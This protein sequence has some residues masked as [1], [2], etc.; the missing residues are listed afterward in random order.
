MDSS[1]LQDHSSIVG[2]PS[3]LSYFSSL[4]TGQIVTKFHMEPSGV[5]RM[6]SCSVGFVHMTNMVITPISG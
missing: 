6:K 2:R 1:E 4:T 5:G 3:T